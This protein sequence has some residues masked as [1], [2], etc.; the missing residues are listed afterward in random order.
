MM[1]KL[2]D[3]FEEMG[4]FYDDDTPTRGIH[5]FVILTRRWRVMKML[6]KGINKR[7]YNKALK[8]VGLLMDKD[9]DPKSKDGRLLNLLVTSIQ[10]YEKNQG[11]Q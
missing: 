5:Q 7:N 10:R 2:F 1:N 9:P 8:E 4:S 6:F 11:W 3:F